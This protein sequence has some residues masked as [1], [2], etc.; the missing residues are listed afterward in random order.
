MSE[1]AAIGIDFGTTNS[2]IA[3]ARPGA[4][5]VLARFE[6]ALGADETFRSVLYFDRG[7]DG[8]QPLSTRAGPHAIARY[9]EA[10]EKNGRLIQS[11]KS[12]LASR[13]FRATQIYGRSYRLEQLIAIILKDL[14]DAAERALDA[15][16]ERAVVGRPVRFVHAE[17][18]SDAELALRRLEAGLHNAGFREV[19]FELEPVGAAYHYE[20]DLDRDELILIADFG[21]GTSDFS[22]LRVGPSWRGA[23][24]RSESILGNDGVP[25]AGDSFDGKLI[26]HLL[27]PLLGR[28]ASFRSQFGGELPVPNWIYGRL[29][30]W[31]HLSLLKTP[32]TMALL[33]D[34]QREA[35]EPEKLDALIHVVRNDLGFLLF[36]A[37]EATKRELSTR[38]RSRFRFRHEHL[39]IDVPVARAQFETW[40]AEEIDAIR[41]C[42]DGLLGRCG[43][44]PAQVDRVFLTG[45]SSFV[46][47][48][49]RVFETR[50]GAERLRFGGELTSVANGLALR[51]LER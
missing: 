48:V 28:G 16:V 6:S 26:R 19:A 50:F 39:D 36:R 40:I 10:E 49:R 8:E 31:H 38:E 17:D 33:I 32:K 47:A 4:P 1:T 41:S 42:V 45:G 23:G 25:V 14:R 18:A 37:V 24:R 27:T 35:F 13:L 2:A 21:G 29:E 34:L 51:A 44:S 15:P 46:P 30:R 9:L 5:P 7:D 3:W 12:F 20:A 22:L 43:L 11:L